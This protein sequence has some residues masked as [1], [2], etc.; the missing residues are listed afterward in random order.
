MTETRLNQIEGNLRFVFVD[1]GSAMEHQVR[2]QLGELFAEIRRLHK[3]EAERCS[4]EQFQI[5]GHLI[6]DLHGV[7]R[8]LST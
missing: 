2:G 1:G 5:E 3:L 6:V 8:P 4:S 7:V